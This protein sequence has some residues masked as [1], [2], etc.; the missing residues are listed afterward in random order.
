MAPRILVVD[1]DRLMIALVRRVLH[2]AWYQVWTAASADEARRLLPSIEDQLDLVLTDV[3]MPGGLGPDVAAMVR[4]SSGR[5]RIAYMSSYD[6]AK[7][8]SHGVD[9]AG[10]PFLAKPFVPEA[11]LDFVATAL[12][13]PGGRSGVRQERPAAQSGGK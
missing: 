11:L 3:V 4:R 1:D 9:L 2:T 13:Q 12:G 6:E 10:A 7:L 8:R 5:I